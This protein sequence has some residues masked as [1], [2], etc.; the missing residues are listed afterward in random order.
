MLLPVT[1]IAEKTSPWRSFNRWRT[2][3]KTVLSCGCLVAASTLA[4][5]LCAT[6]YIPLHSAPTAGLQ[7]P[8][9]PRLF[10]GNCS[11]ASKI[12]TY[13]HFVVNALSS[14]ILL[15]SNMFMQLLLAPTRRQ[16]DIAH[17]KKRSVDI[18]IFSLGNFFV[19][20]KRNRIL[21]V[22]LAFTSLPLHLLQVLQL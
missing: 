5:N 17:A 15:T 20:S 7:Q 19:V 16:I 18:G 10:I 3:R 13:V 21:W 11:Q 1:V 6:V 9:H 2:K 14:L 22:C 4:I 8:L 12:N